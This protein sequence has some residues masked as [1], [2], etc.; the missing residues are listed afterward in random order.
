MDVARKKAEA[1][2]LAKSLFLANMSHEIRTPMNGVLGMANLLRRTSLTGK[3]S[4]F[5]DKIDA[6]GKHLLSIIDDILDLSKIEAGALKLDEQDFELSGLIHDVAAIVETKLTAKG[7]SFHVG[8]SDTPH[9]LRGDRTRL[10]QALVN[11]LGNAVKFTDKGSV[12]LACRKVEETK[13]A[14]LIRFEV[15]DTGIGIKPENTNR[16]FMPFEQADRANSA[17]QASAWR[18]LGT[19]RC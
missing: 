3:Q 16:I 8:I 2:N 15:K 5:L 18:L 9:S 13:D 12:T 14:Y 19:S 17:A 11:Y 6:S 10:T 1:A 4:D 7:L